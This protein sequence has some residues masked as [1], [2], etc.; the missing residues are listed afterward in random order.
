FG[1]TIAPQRIEDTINFLFEKGSDG[2]LAYSEGAF[3]EI[4]KTI[5]AGLASCQFENAYDVLEA[6]AERYLGGDTQGWREWLCQMGD[7]N[8]LNTETARSDFTRLASS[9]RQSWRLQ[10]LEEKL[11][12][13]EAS[14]IV[15]NHNRWT[16]ARITAAEDFWTAKETLWRNIWN[17]GL[18][19]AIL[20]FDRDGIIPE[21]HKE[22][23]QLSN[24]GIKTR[25]QILPDEA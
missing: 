2:F 17:L 8:Q 14:A 1:P 12:M 10:V 7:I 9:S 16:Q 21:W 4:N 13:C 3:D 11:K 25:S 22:Y 5:A 15:K 24:Q 23:R 6:Y 18:G 19:R 20:Q